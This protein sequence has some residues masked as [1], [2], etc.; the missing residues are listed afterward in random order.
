MLEEPPIDASSA[1]RDQ[2]VAGDF[3]QPVERRGTHSAKWD[4]EP[5]EHVLPMWVADMDF[6]T[7]P[8]V[9]QALERRA[10]HGVFGYA[11]IP[12]AYRSAVVDWV[13]QRHGVKLDPLSILPT[14]GVLPAITAILQAITQPGDGV[15]VQTPVYNGFFSCV[16]NAGCERMENPLHRG[17]QGRYQ[18]DFDDLEAKAAH[19]R[20]RVLLLCHPHNPVGRAW[21]LAELQRLRQICAEHGLVVVSDEIHGDLVLPGAHCHIPF[22]SVAGDVSVRTVTCTSPSK[23][24]NLAGL[25][26]AN[27]LVDD[28]TL[29]RR[30]DK[31]ININ[32]TC[33]LNVFAVEA[34]IAA[35]SEGAAWLDGL[36]AYLA[37]NVRL[38]QRFLAEH[39]P[40]L[41]LT[42]MEA[43]YLAWLDVS[44][45]GLP[46]TQ[47]AQRLRH[48]HRLWVNEGTLYGAAGEGF[49]RLN[50]ACP[51]A[52]LQEGLQRLAIGLSHMA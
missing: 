13:A 23:S 37:G 42:P 15:I 3:D 41:S 14:T 43:T 40:N 12:P 32:E 46:S 33:E 30:I 51:R 38:V 4:G 7:A 26:V 47:I 31:A 8:A 19:P 45:M 24:F 5:R 6:R 27:I 9:R 39:L 52:T 21:T 17:E 29:R 36:R 28:A 16:R 1:A 49:L 2:P 10:R 50:L 48:E 20:A 44:S 22:A 34:L 25:Q 18:I 11:H 35:Y